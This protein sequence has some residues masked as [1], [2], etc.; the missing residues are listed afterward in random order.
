MPCPPECRCDWPL[1]QSPA[2]D[3]LLYQVLVVGQRVTVRVVIAKAARFDV[4][5]KSLDASVGPDKGRLLDKKQAAADS[6]LL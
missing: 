6:H 3:D 5:L 1:D 4:T 2:L